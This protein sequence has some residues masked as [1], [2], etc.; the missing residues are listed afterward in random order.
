MNQNRMK[1][2]KR[3]RKKKTN[4]ENRVSYTY[5]LFPI[6]IP[7]YQTNKAAKFKIHNIS[8]RQPRNKDNNFDFGFKIS[9][10]FPSKCEKRLF[11]STSNHF[12]G[13]FFLYRFV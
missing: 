7:K 5:L 11:N 8:K 6:Q 9:V 13:S 12:V 3:R 4:V 2:E 1:K 10:R